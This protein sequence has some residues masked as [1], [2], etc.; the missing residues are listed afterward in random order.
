MLQCRHVAVLERGRLRKEILAGIWS[1]VRG[2]AWTSCP[3]ITKACP[4]KGTLND[5]GAYRKVQR[6]D[7]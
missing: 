2:A 7:W 6:V 3:P 1:I 5:M 4:E